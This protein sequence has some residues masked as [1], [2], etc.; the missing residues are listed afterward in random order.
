MHPR[1]PTL[2]SRCDVTIQVRSSHRG[3]VRSTSQRITS[4]LLLPPLRQTGVDALPGNSMVRRFAH[5]HTDNGSRSNQRHPKRHGPRQPVQKRANP[6]EYEDRR[7][8]Q[9]QQPRHPDDITEQ[10]EVRDD[11]GDSSCYPSIDKCENTDSR[12]TDQNNE[13]VEERESKTGFEFCSNQYTIRTQCRKF[14]CVLRS[15][16]TDCTL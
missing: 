15:M 11:E 7:P 9:F 3:S 14:S 6:E 12:T 4:M 16:T 2:S 5:L 1:W 8:C 13:Q 10:E